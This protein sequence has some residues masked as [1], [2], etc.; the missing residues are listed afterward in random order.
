MRRLVRLLT[1]CGL[2]LI[3]LSM[4][5]A[6]LFLASEPVAHAYAPYKTDLP[7]QHAVMTGHVV[8][9]RAPTQ[10]IVRHFAFHDP[11]SGLDALL[12]SGLQVITHATGFG[13][14]VC[15]IEQV[16]CPA[17]NC[18]CGGSIFWNYSYWDGSAWQGYM[19]GA[20]GS[21][22]SQA[23]AVEGW[24]WG[25]WPSQPPPAPPLVAADLA[26]QW[27]R[28]LQQADGGYGGV[29][30][31]AETLIAGVTNGYDAANWRPQASA[32][33]LAEYV[34]ANA[35]SFVSQAYSPPA[36]AGKLAVAWAAAQKTDWL[37]ATPYCLDYYD[38][39]SGVFYPYTGGASGQAGPQ[40]W[41]MLGLVATSQAVPATATQLLKGLQQ[42]NGGWGWAGSTPDT[43]ATALAIQAL[44][45]SGEPTTSGVI[46]RAL[47]FLK[48]SQNPDGGFH[49]A[50][51]WGTESEVD[52]TAYAIQAILAAGQQ[53]TST[54]WSVGAT[55]PISFLLSMQLS[56]GSFEWKRGNGPNALSTRTAIPA[57]LNR[58]LPITIWPINVKPDC[59]LIY[60]PLVQRE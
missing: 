39:A 13:T 35:G 12:L 5:L 26:L 44:V 42:A 20:D 45:A 47:D 40:S 27:L 24:A 52:S 43:M 3:G 10:T 51:V 23:G 30:P 19:V 29:G 49:Y 56:D 2:G 38:A 50:A 53:P 31:S 28:P 17:D 60:V 32:P 16:G 25:P 1:T 34:A 46:T 58:P 33:S 48:S 21:V 36:A 6:V 57:L 8:V 4:A 9:Q 37:C 11:I 55:D 59:P 41:A 15:S 7:A 18:F 14:A 22:I 54:P